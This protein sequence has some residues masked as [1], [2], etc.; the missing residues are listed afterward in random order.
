MILYLIPATASVAPKNGEV[1]TPAWQKP[2]LK[3]LVHAGK[4]H[5]LA[6][7]NWSIALSKKT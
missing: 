3:T 1:K 4:A 2:I 7:V 5:W 6:Q